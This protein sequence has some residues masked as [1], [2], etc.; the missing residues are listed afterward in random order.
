MGELFGPLH[1]LA[2]AMRALETCS[3]LSGQ[4]KK[5]L[6][7]KTLRSHIGPEEFEKNEEIY[8]LLVDFLVAISKGKYALALNKYAGRK[9]GIKWNKLKKRFSCVS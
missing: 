5:E 2:Q 8:F 6:A 7:L 9:L 4:E 3:T 1:I